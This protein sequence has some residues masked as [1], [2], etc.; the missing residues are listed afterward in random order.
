LEFKISIEG[1]LVSQ[2]I[3]EELNF[4]KDTYMVRL[5]LDLEVAVRAS[6]ITQV[7]SV[8]FVDKFGKLCIRSCTR[9]RAI[10]KHTAL[11]NTVFRCRVCC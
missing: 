8:H 2:L 9:P 6:T 5:V 7:I 10:M 11:N 1:G 3:N 4:I